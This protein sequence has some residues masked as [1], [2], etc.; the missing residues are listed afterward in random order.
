MGL[1]RSTLVV[2][3][4]VLT[5]ALW[6]LSGT[7]RHAGA[8]VAMVAA[9]VLLTVGHR[10]RARRRERRERD[11]FRRLIEAGW[12]PCPR[13]DGSGTF[14]T[15]TGYLGTPVF[16]TCGACRGEGMLPPA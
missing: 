9:G 11:R 10:L 5:A 16:H 8:G 12:T 14:S 7:W 2:G 1:T 6:L 13:C 15:P 4:I 3:G